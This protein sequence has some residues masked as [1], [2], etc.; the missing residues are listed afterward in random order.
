M[1]PTLHCFLP[2]CA[3]GAY[4]SGITPI[5]DAGVRSNLRSKSTEDM[6]SKFDWSTKNVIGPVLDQQRVSVYSMQ[7]LST[8]SVHDEY[9]VLGM[10]VL[11]QE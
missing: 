9:S 1:A 7:L 3:P 2:L 5:V 6:P 4:L 11:L 10:F 8:R